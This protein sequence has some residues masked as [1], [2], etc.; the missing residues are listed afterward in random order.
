MTSKSLELSYEIGFSSHQGKEKEINEDNYCALHRDDEE[1]GS[2]A[3]LAVSDGVG[4]FSLGEIA[5]KIT[6]NNVEKFFKLGEFDQMVQEAEFLEPQRVIQELYTRIN[7]MIRSIMEKENRQVGCTL[8]SGF[9]FQDNVFVASVGNSRAYLLRDGEIRKLTEERG[10]PIIE[11]DLSR[12]TVADGLKDSRNPAFVNS[13]GS[14]IGLSADIKHLH[15]RE[16]DVFLFVSDGLYTQVKEMDIQ[17]A[18]SQE[19]SM[20]SLCSALVQKANDA[21]GR[22]NVTVVAVRLGRYR[23]SFKGALGNKQGGLS[24]SFSPR[25]MIAGLLLAAILFAAT[26]L[27]TKSI[28]TRRTDDKRPAAV[29]HP[30]TRPAYKKAY[31]SLTLETGLPVKLLKVNGVGQKVTDKFQT[32]EFISTGNEIRVMPDVSGLQPGLYA[33][34]IMGA[35]RDLQ[36]YQKKQN[37]VIL[38]PG[39]MEVHLTPGS[40]LDYATRQEKK[41]VKFVATIDNLGTPFEVKMEE[42]E[43]IYISLKPDARSHAAAPPGAGKPR[44]AQPAPEGDE[45]EEKPSP[46]KGESL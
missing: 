19:K 1:F 11:R 18:A 43:N 32:F 46:G 26:F 10:E 23:G 2:R 16:G 8:V 17:E 40:R 20:Q 45:P 28:L 42:Q 4:G 25:V 38:T 37:K 30:D 22:D 36:V 15:G 7:H 27:G 41:G 35:D 14:D 12:M 6:V 29:Y 31:N 33:I 5:S 21:G 39:K 34:T 9:F 3:L 24:R 44:P 13:L